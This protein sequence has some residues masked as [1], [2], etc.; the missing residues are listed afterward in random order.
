M[1]P[2]ISS[3][4]GGCNPVTGALPAAETCHLK[5]DLRTSQDEIDQP[6]PDRLCQRR[7]GDGQQVGVGTVFDLAVPTGLRRLRIRAPGSV[8]LDTTF[9]VTAGN[10]T[11]LGLITLRSLP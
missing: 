2:N 8:T 6:G 1:A 10:T 7:P 4:G 11:R 3:A 9:Q 5:G